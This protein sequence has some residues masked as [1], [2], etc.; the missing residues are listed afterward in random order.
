MTL[1]A[2]GKFHRAS[3]AQHVAGRAFRRTHSQFLR[4]LAEHS[5]DGLRLA[6]VALRCRGAVRVDVLNVGPDS[7]ARS[8]MPFSCSALRLRLRALEQSCGSH[9]QCFRSRRVRNRCVRHEPSRVP[10]LPARTTP[11]PSPMTKPSRSLSNGR[12]ERFGSSLRVL[13]A[14]IAQKPPMPIGTMVASVPPATSL[15]RRPF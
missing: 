6:Q 8:S 3:R 11:A 5:F 15:A 10:I 1:H 9:P 7:G 14:F 4:V 2:H 13:M 12:D